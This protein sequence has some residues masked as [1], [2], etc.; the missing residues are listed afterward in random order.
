MNAAIVDSLEK[1]VAKPDGLLFFFVVQFIRRQSVEL[2][3]NVSYSGSGSFCYEPLSNQNPD[4]T[5]MNI[6]TDSATQCTIDTVIMLDR[7]G[8]AECGVPTVCRY[9]YGAFPSAS[10]STV[11][12]VSPSLRSAYCCGTF[13]CHRLCLH[14]VYCM[15]LYHIAVGS[16]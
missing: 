10:Y 12:L 4:S 11:L 13:T 5:A 14:A 2:A 3:A 9:D 1:E 15:Y 6:V 16:R 7:I 8:A